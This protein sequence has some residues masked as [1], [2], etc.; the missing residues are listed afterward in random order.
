MTKI[1]FKLRRLRGLHD[2]RVTKGQIKWGW[3]LQTGSVVSWLANEIKIFVRFC[4][5][6][7]RFILIVGNCG[8]YWYIPFAFTMLIQINIVTDE[9][10]SCNVHIS[11]K[12]GFAPFY[13]TNMK[14]PV[15]LWLYIRHI[16]L[17]S[18][19]YLTGEGR[20]FFSTSLVQRHQREIFLIS[21][22]MFNSTK[23]IF[24]SYHFNATLVWRD[25]T[26]DISTYI[27]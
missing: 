20:G 19:H 6:V 23:F 24:E 26:I 4:Y 8:Q 21:V 12:S 1:H 5:R 11:A 17:M 18:F 27:S 16:I 25:P 3:I 15:R 22:P 13:F 14:F 7:C 2:R 10:M 9:M